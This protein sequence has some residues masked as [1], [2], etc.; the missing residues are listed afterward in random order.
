MATICEKYKVLC[1]HDYQV[2]C[3]S[4]KPVGQGDEETTTLMEI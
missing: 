3:H 1:F 2:H 4:H